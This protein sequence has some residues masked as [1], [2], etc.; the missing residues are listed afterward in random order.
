MQSNPFE[1]AE[2]VKDKEA[3]EDDDITPMKI[4]ELEVV[5]EDFLEDRYSVISSA[6]QGLNQSARP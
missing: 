5:D 4:D 1:S 3:Q 6:K 2:T